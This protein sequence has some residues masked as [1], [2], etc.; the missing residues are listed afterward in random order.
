MDSPPF[1]RSHPH[2]F[3]LASAPGSFELGKPT[4]DDTAEDEEERCLNRFLLPTGEMVSCVFW[5]GLY[6]ITG[7]DIAR[8][9]RSA[10][11]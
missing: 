4:D 5:N 3:F 8:R 1:R 7:T 11:C 10:A 2:R 9:S 6:H